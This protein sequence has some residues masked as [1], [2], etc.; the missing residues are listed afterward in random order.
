MTAVALIRHGPTAWTERRR[1]Q[2]RSDPG[3]SVAGRARVT[4][5]RAPPEVDGFIWLSSPLT[6]ASETARL[7][8]GEDVVAEP[9][10][11]EMDW[12][13]W[14]GRSLD[15]LRGE[16]GDAMAEN[17]ALGLDFTPAG[18][19]SPR[20]VQARLQNWLSAIAASRQATVG[21][22]HKG[23]IRAMLS[24]ATGWDMTVPPPTHL[25]WASAHMFR[26]DNH[27]MPS[28]ERLNIGLEVS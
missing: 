12:G 5:W 27:G 1:I 19:E 25:D 23:I 24:L 10:L 13:T 7:L 18:G 11:I 2:G 15:D 26:L 17:E 3:L 28:I 20:Q 14:E 16:L 4:E 22:T 6:R 8:H 9:S 21:V